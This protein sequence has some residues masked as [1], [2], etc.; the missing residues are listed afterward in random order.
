MEDRVDFSEVDVF[1]EPI[2]LF[3]RYESSF[4]L[5]AKF[6]WQESFVVYGL[7]VVLDGDYSCGSVL[8][9]CEEFFE[10][11]WKYLVHVKVA[12]DDDVELSVR[13]DGRFGYG[14]FKVA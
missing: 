12:D 2:E 9:L 14:D 6:Q 3:Y 5:F 1:G 10:R 8:D 7:G 4:C 13:D 11:S